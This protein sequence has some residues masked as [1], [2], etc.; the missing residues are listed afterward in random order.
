MVWWPKVG[1]VKLR[2]L[3]NPCFLLLENISFFG[4]GIGG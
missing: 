3:G 2:G 1:L 4:F